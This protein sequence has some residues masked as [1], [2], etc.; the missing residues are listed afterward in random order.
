ML[1]NFVA[2]AATASYG[3]QWIAKPS[4]AYTEPPFTCT[5]CSVFAGEMEGAQLVR[6]FGIK[7]TIFFN[8]STVSRPAWSRSV[9]CGL[10]CQPPNPC[11]DHSR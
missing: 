6:F 4:A 8:L 11:V 10:V 5:M 7:C 2:L 3:I 9:V 1:E